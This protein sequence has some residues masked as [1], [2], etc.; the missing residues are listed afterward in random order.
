MFCWIII[1]A[2]S[3]RLGVEVVTNRRII[4]H[5]CPYRSRRIDTPYSIFALIRGT[6]GSSFSGE[7]CRPQGRLDVAGSRTGPE[8]KVQPARSQLIIHGMPNRSTSMPKPEDQKVCCSGIVTVP[9]SDIARNI[10]SASAG[11]LIWI[12]TEKPPGS[13]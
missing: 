13:S 11:S 1:S 5:E 7:M 8:K 2:R 10:D 12:K 4:I 6:R 3:H 9:P